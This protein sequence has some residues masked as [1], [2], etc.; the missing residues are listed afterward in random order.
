[1]NL[2]DPV[3]GYCP[4]QDSLLDS[5]EENIQDL[6]CAIQDALYPSLNDPVHG[7]ALKHTIYDDLWDPL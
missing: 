1:M 5:F 2:G 3:T 6:I 7:I 4:L